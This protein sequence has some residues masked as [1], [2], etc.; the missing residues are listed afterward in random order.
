M[1]K[2]ML[3]IAAA[4][5]SMA[6]MAETT[7]ITITPNGDTWVRNDKTANYGKDNKMEVKTNYRTAK[8]VNGNDSV[9]KDD[10]FVGLLSFPLPVLPEGAIKEAKLVLTTE[11]IKGDRGVNIYALGTDFDENTVNYS[12]VESLIVATRK[13]DPLATFTAKGQGEKACI[14]DKIDSA[15]QDV[16]AWQD[17]IDLTAYVAACKS[18]NLT[19]FL[20]RVK[21][22]QANP[23][24]FF[25][26]EQGDFTPAADGKGI[27]L[28][29][30][31]ACPKLLLTYDGEVTLPT[32]INVNTRKGYDNLKTAV[33]SA[34]AG[35]HI[36]ISE[37]ITYSGERINVLKELT[38]EGATGKEVVHVAVAPN[39]LFLLANG[40]EAD[41][42]LTLKNLTFHC[43]D[44]VRSIQTFDT[45][46][47]AKM[48]FENVVVSNVSYSVITGDVKCNGSNISL[49]GTNTFCNGIYLNKNKRVDHA[50]A[51]H[52]TPVSIILAADYTEDYAIVLNCKDSLLYTAKDA[53][54][55][56]WLL[57]VSAGKELKGKNLKNA[58]V[59]ITEYTLVGDEALVGSNWDVNDA[60]NTM[61]LADSVLT[62]AK[63]S[64]VLEAKTYN[65]KVVGNHNYE[66]AQY[67]A[68]TDNF[69]LTISEAGTYDVVFTLDL[70]T[71]EGNA[72]ATKQDST[73]LDKAEVEAKCVKRV[74]NGQV[75]LLSNGVRYNILGAKL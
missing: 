18:A 38:I 39:Q 49:H 68:G 32:I 69:T 55:N 9:T 57:Y 37:D 21:T 42:T 52:T 16:R 22:E 17:T 29:A 28:T 34:S 20:S 62:I 61:S 24:C 15:Y 75:V 19:L 59:E 30:A 26:K 64:V 7:N 12:D 44:S 11:R 50:G 8:D 74:E 47:K 14:I 72:E 31:E 63:K 4:L 43:G 1:K 71:T 56:D 67:P 73:A 10:D 60:A 41:Y 23:V 13:S 70:T 66:V 36:Q 46:G 53:D 3:C 27:A 65:W 40:N 54:G 35:D 48:T 2:T 33:D 6:A 58:P 25:T 45:N 51:T 5:L